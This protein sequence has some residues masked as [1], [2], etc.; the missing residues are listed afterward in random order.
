VVADLSCPSRSKIRT[1]RPGMFDM[2]GKAKWD[3]WEKCK[4]V[5]KE[6]AMQKYCEVIK[7]LS[8]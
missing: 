5:S 8:A 7:R 6:E 4:G 3:A 1:A 2:K